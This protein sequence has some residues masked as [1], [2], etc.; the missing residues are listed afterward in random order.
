MESNKSVLSMVICSNQWKHDSLCR[1]L[2]FQKI[3]MISVFHWENTLYCHRLCF[4]FLPGNMLRQKLVRRDMADKQSS[5]LKL[6]MHVVQDFDEMT[7][8]GP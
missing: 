8:L 3:P 7:A 1:I 4:F 2:F 6:H 5:S